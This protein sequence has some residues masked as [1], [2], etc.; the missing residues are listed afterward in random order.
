MASTRLRSLL[1][2]IV[3]LA[4]AGGGRT[5]E[6]VAAFLDAL[7]ESGYYDAALMYLDQ[8]EQSPLA[9]AAFRARIAYERGV[10]MV[11]A[12]SID[13]D[14]TSREQK[15][16]N[17]QISLE[18]FIRDRGD[19]PLAAL[20]R[21]Q[22][23]N[24]VYERARLKVEQSSGANRA[25]LLADA[26]GLYDQA[27]KIFT[28]SANQAKKDLAEIP[29]ELDPDSDRDTL[30]RRE[31]LRREFLQAT[32]LTAVVSEEKAD[33]VAE[34]S[35]ERKKILE[36]AAAQYD[37]MFSKYGKY[38]AGLYARMYSGRVQ[39]K[40]GKF[41]QALTCFKEDLLKQESDPLPFRQLKTKTLLLAMD[42]WLDDAVKKYD[43]AVAVGTSWLAE[44]R[45]NESSE[46]DWMSLRLKVADAHKRFADQL[47]AKDP[48]DKQVRQSYDEARK[49]A[50]AV[51][52]IPGEFQEAA[53][54]MLAELPGGVGLAAGAE[55]KKPETFEEARV[56][57]RESLS[58]MQNADYILDSLQ[59]RIE[60]EKDEKIREEL[61]A[62]IEEAR[63]TSE[64]SRTEA[65]E[66][67]QLAMQMADSETPFEDLNL[68]RYYLAYLH[69]QQ[70]EYYD[71]A[72]LGEFL[73]RR[74]PGGTS[75]K[76]AA[77]VALAA[78]L[79]LFEDA[80][81]DNRFESDHVV[82]L[83]DYIVETWTGQPEAASAI[84]TLV[85]FLIKRGEV[86]RARQYVDRIPESSAERGSAELRIGQA[87]WRDFR[88]GSEQLSQWEAQAKESDTEAAALAVKIADRRKELEQLKT[89]SLGILETGVERMKKASELDITVPVAVLT[90]MQIYTD[91]DQ[92]AKAIALLDDEK[93]GP[94]AMIA[95]KDPLMQDPRLIEESY[96][97]A[98][99]A[100]VAGLPK[101]PDTEQRSKLIERARE[102]MQQLRTQVGEAPEDQ[103]RLVAIFYSMAR[104]L[105]RQIKLLDNAQDRKVLSEGFNT[106]LD[107]VRTQAT[108]I[109]VLNWVAESY[110]GLGSG[111]EDDASSSD[112]GAVYFKKAV[113]TYDQILA[114]AQAEGLSETLVQQLSV[115]KAIALRR[116]GEYEGAIK[117]FTQVLLK[118][119]AKL[120][121][122]V[123][124]ARTYQD[125][126]EVKGQ[127]KRYDNAVK[128][129]MYQKA[130]KQYVIWGWKKIA[131]LSQRY[132]KFRDTFYE[133]QYNV[134][135]C[136]YKN[137]LRQTDEAA[138]A[139]FLGHAKRDLTL[140]Q[141]LHPDLGGAKWRDRYNE[142][143]KQVQRALKEEP[144]GLAA[145]G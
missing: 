96:K 103:K 127:A 97:S 27:F 71:A 60:R 42:C 124:A 54:L 55:K 33:T 87:M 90:L 50:R 122:Q 18:A 48:R 5:E 36:S 73:A 121:I 76:P 113:E 40:L 64:S 11:M 1:A 116:A 77:E 61:E 53:R 70:G 46:P 125:W 141:K 68:V 143:M 109:S 59:Q 25:A 23:G 128:G 31:E 99:S 134:A 47:K 35:P 145:V 94:L 32:L 39:M 69:F 108:D 2:G 34:D 129:G 84:S 66:Y 140:T 38:L 3:I 82:S 144:V 85:P 44:M 86:D 132:P 20:A 126:A 106:F 115:S 56:A 114:M 139:T 102:T 136:H 119:N 138:R 130:K 28:E 93:I 75:A 83:A 43:E 105:E 30:E 7:R 137:A 63:N 120:N 92:A 118:D 111:L 112:A 9:P 80:G 8:M 72:V 104:G 95:R 6:P 142:L 79:K 19:D 41:D 12:A 123:E 101:A 52:R 135:V 57:G 16:N 81:E 24:L 91:T 13:R 98:L 88:S 51:S 67:L 117:I 14:L 4:L 37:E 17:A 49:L 100:L 131:S 10:T 29:K 15:L 22:F 133:A 58:A 45:P 78:Y 74:F 107:E 65:L 26:S 89:A 110:V 62:S 21:R